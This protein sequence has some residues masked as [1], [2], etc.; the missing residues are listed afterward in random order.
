MS[1]YWLKVESGLI[2]VV[3]IDTVWLVTSQK[4]LAGQVVIVRSMASYELIIILTS[5]ML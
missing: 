2:Y 3:M 5:W 1:G 4:W